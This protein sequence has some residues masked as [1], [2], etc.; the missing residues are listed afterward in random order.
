MNLVHALLASQ[1]LR[2]D[3][4]KSEANNYKY[5]LLNCWNC[6]WELFAASRYRVASRFDFSPA[7]KASASAEYAQFESQSP[8]PCTLSDTTFRVRCC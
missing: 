2:R 5:D 1:F 3:R 4:L 6:I 8:R 7:R